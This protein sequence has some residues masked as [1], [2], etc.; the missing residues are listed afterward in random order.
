MSTK[1]AE[2]ARRFNENTEKT[3]WH[4]A[5]FWSVRKKRDDMA[6]GLPEWEDLRELA[7]QIKRHTITHLAD[8]L[9]QFSSQLESRGVIVHWAKDA[10]EFNQTVLSILKTHG[11]DKMVKS[12]SMLTEECGMNAYLEDHG[13]DVVETDLGERILQLLH[14][15]PSHIVMPAIH[16][17]REEVGRMF[18]EKGIS[19]DKGNYDPTYLTRCAREH[20]RNQFLEAGA[21]M[22]G[23]NFGVANTGDIVVCTNE[24][25]ADMSTS[26]PKLHLVAMG[27]EKIVPD[28]QSLAVFQRLL[29]R[30]AT[31]Q[32]TTSYTSHFRKARPGAEM[33]V[34]L[35]DN[36]R[37]DILANEEHWETLKCIRCGACMNTCPVYRRSG[38]YSYTYFIPGPIGINLGML[39]DARR[40]ADNVSACTLCLSCDKMCPAKVAPGSQVYLWRQQLDSLGCADPMKKTMSKAMKVLFERPALYDCALGL[41]PLA[42]IIPERMTHIRALNPWSVGHDMPEFA[43]ESFQSLWK[44]GK[45]K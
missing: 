31:G 11:V 15:K 24:G 29:C 37:S 30:S 9:E 16:L 13:I 39:R 27:L 1:H 3:T 12:K 33:H 5:T 28:Y 41:A 20:L 6:H 45:V 21:G 19:K 32:P 42:N 10:D 17:K 22:T 25:N 40:Y 8:Y 35:V 38:G 26:V 7:S 44:K 14:Q 36:G 43:R 2:A 34:I 23:C 18:E 4:D